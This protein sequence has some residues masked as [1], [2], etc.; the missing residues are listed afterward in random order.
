VAYM[1]PDP[2]LGHVIAGGSCCSAGSC[3]CTHVEVGVCCTPCRA[4]KVPQHKQTERREGF[5]RVCQQCLA[6]LCFFTVVLRWC[7]VLRPLCS[8]HARLADDC[9]ATPGRH[10][11]GVG[12]TPWGML[13]RKAGQVPWVLLPGSCTSC[14]VFAQLPCRDTVTA[15][16]AMQ[17]VLMVVEVL[18]CGVKLLRWQA[19]YM[20][21]AASCRHVCV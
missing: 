1:L 4:W 18:V 10:C 15:T 2:A 3:C 8:M 11:S 12:Y 5:G 20:L 13:C 21:L 6:V 16:D 17:A 19:V 14:I 9:G 7:C